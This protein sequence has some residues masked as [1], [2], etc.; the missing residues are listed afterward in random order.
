[1]NSINIEY[2]TNKIEQVVNQLL[3][4][5][6]ITI[7]KS[8]IDYILLN[9]LSSKKYVKNV[10]ISSKKLTTRFKFGYCF[11]DDLHDLI[12]SKG[13]TVNQFRFDTARII[14]FFELF[15]SDILNQANNNESFDLNKLFSHVS[16]T[17]NQQLNLFAINL[18]LPTNLFQTVYH[19]AQNEYNQSCKKHPI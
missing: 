15:E 6:S 11:E 3:K 10:K 18:L 4:N 13:T 12:I 5:Q 17:A 7:T 8:R 1:M 2:S 9:N 14:G 16:Q 19:L